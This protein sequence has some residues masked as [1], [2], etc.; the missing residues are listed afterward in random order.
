M[1]L[2]RRVWVTS[3][4]F[5]FQFFHAEAEAYWGNFFETVSSKFLAIISKFWQAFSKIFLGQMVTNGYLVLYVVG[6]PWKT[7]ILRTTLIRN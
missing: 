2:S 3:I 4:F 7:N 6:C 5:V 1:G